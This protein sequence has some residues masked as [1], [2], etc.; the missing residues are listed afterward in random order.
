ILHPQSAV[1]TLI[2]IAFLAVIAL[3]SYSLGDGTPMNLVGY[4]GPDNVPGMLIMADTFLYS[5][6]IL[7]GGAFLA[8]LYTEVSRIFK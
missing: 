7:L 5:M 1:R 8:I 6:Y 2:S 3:I 4:K